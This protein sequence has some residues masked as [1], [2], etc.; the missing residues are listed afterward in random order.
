[1]SYQLAKAFGPLHKP[2]VPANSDAQGYL[3]AEKPGL[4]HYAVRDS[5]RESSYRP[6]AANVAPRAGGWAKGGGN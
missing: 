1:M 3:E 4:K 6:P 2:Y 5:G